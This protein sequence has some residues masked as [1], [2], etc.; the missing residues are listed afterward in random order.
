MCFY[1]DVDD[2]AE[3]RNIRH[4]DM[5]AE[6]KFILEKWQKGKFNVGWNEVKQSITVIIY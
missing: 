3:W 6:L 5:F 4:H 2:V 1:Y